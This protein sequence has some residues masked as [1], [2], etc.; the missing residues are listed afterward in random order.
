RTEIVNVW[1]D[2]PPGIETVPGNWIE[3]SVAEEDR[4]TL[5]PPGDAGRVRV[6]VPVTW[7]LPRSVCGFSVRAAKP[8]KSRPRMRYTWPLLFWNASVSSPA[9]ISLLVAV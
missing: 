2:A 8:G 6:T 7:A 1:V 9:L 4:E 5:S 3:P